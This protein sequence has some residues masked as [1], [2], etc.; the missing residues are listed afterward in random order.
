MVIENVPEN[1]IKKFLD[2]NY[3]LQDL[4]YL[5][6]MG[7]DNI[8]KNLFFLLAIN[9]DHFKTLEIDPQTHRTNMI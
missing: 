7:F 9:I 4:E 1:I 6:F 3:D 5:D 2:K 8:I